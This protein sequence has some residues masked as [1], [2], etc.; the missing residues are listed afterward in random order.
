MPGG[1]SIRMGI[2][3]LLV[4][5]VPYPATMTKKRKRVEDEEE[6]IENAAATGIS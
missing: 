3:S 1:I 5:A 4:G 6:E 2:N